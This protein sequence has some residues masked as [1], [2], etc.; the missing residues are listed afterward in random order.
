MSRCCPCPHSQRKERFHPFYTAGIFVNW[1]ATARLVLLFFVFVRASLLP[2][3]TAMSGP[4]VP[5]PP[6]MCALQSAMANPERMSQAMNLMETNPAMAQMAQQMMQDP[7]ALQRASQ[8]DLGG[9]LAAGINAGGNP[10][11]GFPPPMAGVGG[12]GGFAMPPPPAPAP[13]TDAAAAPVPPPPAT[14]AQ[15]AMLAAG[16]IAEA[17]QAEE[18][19]TED[20]LVAEAIRRSMEDI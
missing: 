11:R 16:G 20:E 9:A 15:A 7:A 10:A 5:S 12:Q 13:T 3:S 17:A 6:P 8:M 4:P 14:D 18:E 1:S 2:L 19:M